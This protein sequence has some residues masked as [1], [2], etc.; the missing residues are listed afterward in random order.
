MENNDFEVDP[1]HLGGL[2]ADALE[3]LLD[4]MPSEEVLALPQLKLA[5]GLNVPAAK[6]V[7]LTQLL[8]A[9]PAAALADDDF[10]PKVEAAIGDPDVGVGALAVKVFVHWGSTERGLTAVLQPSVV[11]ALH[12]RCR[13]DPIGMLRVAEV[14]LGIASSSPA[15][16][17]QI[18]ASNA[19]LP[20]FE[21]LESD[22]PL[23]RLAAVELVRETVTVAAGVEMLEQRGAL[24]AL[25]ETLSVVDSLEGQVLTPGILSL[26]AS[27]AK[28]P[29]VDAQGMLTTHGVLRC[30][31][32]AVTHPEISEQL[33]TAGLDAGATVASIPGGL[34]IVLSG[35]TD[36][37]LPGLRG[38]INGE[39]GQQLASAALHTLARLLDPE[40]HTEDDRAAAE[41]TF[42]SVAGERADRFVEAVV[43]RARRPFED[44]KAAGFHL[45]QSVAGHGWGAAV[46]LA[47][48][49]FFEWI[50]DRRGTTKQEREWK[51]AIGQRIEQRGELTELQRD[52]LREWLRQGPHYRRG[53]TGDMEVATM[54]A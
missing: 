11:G 50:V 36:R 5:F 22:D 25:G 41:R 51:Y 26:F 28:I 21:H 29:D 47:H 10:L 33:C 24:G 4:G 13:A 27:L 54:T 43:E 23:A 2:A 39:A 17:S 7:A 16:L 15:A 9:P 45:L 49:G 48:R 30:I 52:E 3:Q 38:L 32:H 44:D 40:S 6:K 18:A 31:E 37:F 8:R 14:Y 34:Q 12:E 35:T 1:L 46:L 20:L 19:L 53:V 42:A